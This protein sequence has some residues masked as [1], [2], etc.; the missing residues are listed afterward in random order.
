V[1]DVQEELQNFNRRR[2]TEE[3]EL[4]EKFKQKNLK[5]NG[6]VTELEN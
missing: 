1:K 4:E 5:L 3:Q 6:K 2:E